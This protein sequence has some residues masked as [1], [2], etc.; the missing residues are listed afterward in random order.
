MFSDD[1]S[2]E[3]ALPAGLREKPLDLGFGQRDQF[4]LRFPRGLVRRADNQSQMLAATAR[5]LPAVL[6]A[7]IIDRVFVEDP[8]NG[9]IEQPR[10]FQVGDRI[11]VPEIYRH[12]RRRL[13][14]VE[15]GKMSGGELGRQH[16]PEREI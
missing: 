2:V 5:A 11:V 3:W 4:V 16:T 13:E 10:E 1:K 9:G 8:F 12:Y 7:V 15:R 6:P 14:V